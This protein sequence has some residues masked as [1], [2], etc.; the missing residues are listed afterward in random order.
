MTEPTVPESG[1]LPTAAAHRAHRSRIPL[2]WAVPVVAAII[3]AWLGIHA[4]LDR[5]PTITVTFLDAEGIE[6]GKTKVRYES[7]D[8]GTVESV[9]P[10]PDRR[11]VNVT[12]DTAKFA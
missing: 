4:Y 11:T 8:I 9:A 12:I 6:A 1:P 3:G 7:V 5:G 10:A 2:V